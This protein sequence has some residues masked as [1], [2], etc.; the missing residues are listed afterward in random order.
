[1]VGI[2]QA[3]LLTAGQLLSSDRGYSVFLVLCVAV[4]LW[5]EEGIQEPVLTFGY[6]QHNSLVLRGAAAR[7]FQFLRATDPKNTR[8]SG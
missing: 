7:F 2:R 4:I 1:M 6:I 5:E 3:A 8:V